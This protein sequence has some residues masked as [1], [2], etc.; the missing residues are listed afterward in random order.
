MKPGVP[1][2]MPCFSYPLSPSDAVTAFEGWDAI[3]A[4]TQPL[5][6]NPVRG[7][8]E[9]ATLIYTSG[10]TGMPKGVMHVVWQLCLGPGQGHQAHPDVGRRPHAVLSAAGP[11]G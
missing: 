9:L 10:T 6:G 5:K 1:A 7:E 2:D 4:R 11:R 8:D 3:C